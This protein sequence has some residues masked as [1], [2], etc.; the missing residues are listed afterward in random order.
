MII[1]IYLPPYGRIRRMICDLGASYTK[2]HV[3]VKVNSA[4]KQSVTI[5]FLGPAL[6]LPVDPIS[7][8]GEGVVAYDKTL[9]GGPF[10]KIDFTIQHQKTGQTTW[11]DNVLG[12]PVI[13]PNHFYVGSEDY[14]D[15]D[16]NDTIIDIQFT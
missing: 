10:S 3:V 16:Y 6:T 15:N 2:A 11:E 9:T 7:G 4:F 1:P 14:T 8:I 5:K 12:N 13:Q